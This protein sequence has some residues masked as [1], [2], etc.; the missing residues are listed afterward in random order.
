MRHHNSES[1]EYYSNNVSKHGSH[2]GYYQQL[3]VVWRP[4]LE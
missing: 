2:N 4:T 3:A 1:H